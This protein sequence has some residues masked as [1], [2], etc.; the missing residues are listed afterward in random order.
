MANKEYT[1]RFYF[2]FDSFNCVTVCKFFLK[3]SLYEIQ[4]NFS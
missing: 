4:P 3:D 1:R 2:S